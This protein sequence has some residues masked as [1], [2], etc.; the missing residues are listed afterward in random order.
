MSRRL[1]FF[2]CTAIVSASLQL[3]SMTIF[4][5]ELRELPTKIYLLSSNLLVDIRPPKPPILM[6][7]ITKYDLFHPAVTSSTPFS[8]PA[9]TFQCF[10][11]VRANADEY[12]KN[13]NVQIGAGSDITIVTLGTGS[14]LPSKYRNGILF[15]PSTMFLTRL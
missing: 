8:L 7:S 11:A 5:T 13:G 1:S 15:L 2:H 3:F 12:M 6:E 4:L 9:S 14:A 10:S